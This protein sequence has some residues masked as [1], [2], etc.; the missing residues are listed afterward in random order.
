MVKFYNRAAV[1]QPQIV[2]LRGEIGIGKTR[3]AT[4]FINWTYTQGTEVLQGDAFESSNHMPFQPLLEALQL[5]LEREVT[6]QDWLKEIWSVPLSHLMPEI[7]QRYPNLPSFPPVN[8]LLQTEEGQTQFFEPF[9]R[10]TLALAKRAPLVLFVDDVQWADSATLELLPYAIRRWQKSAAR[11]LLLVNLRSESLHPMAQ[12]WQAGKPTGIIEWLTLVERELTPC[13]IELGPL[14]K[15]ETI[16]MVQSILSPSTMD[17]AQ[18]VFDETNGQPFYLMET[19]KDLIERRV[20]HP[21]RQAEGRWTFELDAEHDLGKTIRVPSTVR[22]V[23]RSRLNRLSPNAFNLLTAGAILE[24]YITFE[25][26]CTI[27]NITEDL[28]LAALDEL[29]SSRLLL[30][31]SQPETASVYI[32]ANDMTRDVVY[33]EAGDARR[34]LF[35]RRALETLKTANIPAAVLAHHALAAGLAEAAFHYCLV[36]GREALNLSVAGESIIHFEQALR[37]VQDASLPEAPA[38]TDLHDLYMH[39]GRAYEL[40]GQ[41]EKAVSIYKELERRTQ[42]P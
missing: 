12:P 40:S 20:L 11:I 15:Q 3:L 42:K 7:H 27:S 2:V 26:L 16:Q 39:L 35:H 38:E 41:P 18:W 1:G 10:L 31:T 22:A 28:G 17:F 9:V 32:F 4:E 14:G 29:V 21:K 30:E 8:T 23:I 33:T 6:T 19:L 25:R 34:H 24:Q 37:L 5:R 36:A 13:H